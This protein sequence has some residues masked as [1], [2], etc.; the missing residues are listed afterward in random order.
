MRKAITD[1]DARQAQGDGGDTGRRHVV[2]E[3]R[4]MIDKDIKTYQAVIKAANLK[5][6]LRAC[7]STDALMPRSP[8]HD[9]LRPERAINSGGIPCRPARGTIVR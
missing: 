1:P 8:G 6:Q 2:A 5:L 7:A 9:F 4:D 3:F